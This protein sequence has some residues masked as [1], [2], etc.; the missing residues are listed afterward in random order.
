MTRGALT[1]PTDYEYRVLLVVNICHWILLGCESARCRVG[2]VKERC[3]LLIL[4]A[5][6]RG[7]VDK[8]SQW[9]SSIKAHEEVSDLP[10]SASHLVSSK[11]PYNSPRSSTNE[12]SSF[13]LSK[14]QRH[15][16]TFVGCSCRQGRC[17]S[18]DPSL[19]DE[20]RMS[21]LMIHTDTKIEIVRAEWLNHLPK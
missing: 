19:C 18:R 12:A 11:D 10:T 7:G 13:Y 8:I 2:P 1:A 21:L 9:H 5:S 20:V 15:H 6:A 16:R 17:T 14:Q 3:I 4:T